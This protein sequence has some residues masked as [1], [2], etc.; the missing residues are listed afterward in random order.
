MRGVETHWAWLEQIAYHIQHSPLG[1]N[2]QEVAGHITLAKV[3][4]G[5]LVEKAA[6]EAQQVLGGAG[7]QK[8]EGVGGKVEQIS[9]DLMMIVVGGRSEEILADLAIRQEIG[10]ARK[11]SW[12]L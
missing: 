9:R 8:G 11:K 1:F 2:S 4:D 3:T 10:N 5:K 6:R 7:Y 12:K